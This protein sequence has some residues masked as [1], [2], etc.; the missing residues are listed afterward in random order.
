M[1]DLYFNEESDY[2]EENTCYI[3]VFRST[4]LRLFQYEPEQKK[5]CGNGSHEKETKHIHA[6]TGD[7]LH[8]RIANLDWCKCRHC[9]SEAREIGLSLL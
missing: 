3:E 2:S 8:T 7:L 6:S 4:I 5:T 9:K 1:S